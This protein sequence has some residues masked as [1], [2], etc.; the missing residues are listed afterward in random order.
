[1]KNKTNRILS[2][3]MAMVML[4]TV[5]PMTA[6]AA[7]TQKFSDVPDTAWYAEAIN[8]MADTG[9]LKGDGT[10]K[11][12]PDSPITYGEFATLLC[13][14]YGLPVGE[15]KW[16]YN[17]MEGIDC[18]GSYSWASAAIQTTSNLHN[19]LDG[20]W[21]YLT[22]WECTDANE[23]MNRGETVVYLMIM[24]FHM[25]PEVSYSYVKF[26][27]DREANGETAYRIE[28]FKYTEPFTTVDGVTTTVT[29]TGKRIAGVADENL[30]AKPAGSSSA[31]HGWNVKAI[32]AAYALDIVHGDGN[33]YFNPANTLT[34]AEL[35]QLLY[36]MGIMEP[37]CVKCFDV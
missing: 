34:R 30:N 9:L 36:N 19:K 20:G 3:V 11:F 29:K 13:R 21:G 35:C 16:H 4:M 33:G 2:L 17:K 32:A 12:N 28:E 5:L 6:S 25:H 1:M 26:I 18:D 27:N 7:G 10:G 22:S 8:A 14:I 15:H 24:Y 31:K 23:L 37:G